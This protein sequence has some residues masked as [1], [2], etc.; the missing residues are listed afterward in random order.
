[1]GSA[2]IES[3]LFWRN[4]VSPQVSTLETFFFDP[5]GSKKVTSWPRRWIPSLTATA[6]SVGVYVTPGAAV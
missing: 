1:M 3:S 5:S 4:A 2:K 6:I